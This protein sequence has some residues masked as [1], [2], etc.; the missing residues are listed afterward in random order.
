MLATNK[1]IICAQ[2][3]REAVMKQSGIEVADFLVR[4][5]LRKEMRLGYRLAKTVAIQ[6]NSERCLVLR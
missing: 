2:Q 1:A 6:S 3:V 5:V 4:Q